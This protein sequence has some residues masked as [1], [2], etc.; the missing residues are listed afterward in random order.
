ME[1]V[2]GWLEGTPTATS[3]IES[4]CERIQNERSGYLYLRIETKQREKDE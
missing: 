2:D 1:V 4:G 3:K